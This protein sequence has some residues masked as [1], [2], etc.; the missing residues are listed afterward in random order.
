MGDHAEPMQQH[1][2]LIA[3][4]GTIPLVVFVPHDGHEPISGVERRRNRDAP[5]EATVRDVNTLPRT[6]L[7]ATLPPRPCARKPVCALAN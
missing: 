2:L 6:A 1:L 5:G 4:Q 7:G 3:R